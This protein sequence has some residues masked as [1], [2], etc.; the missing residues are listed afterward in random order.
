MLVR[1]E[2]VLWEE[3][4]QLGPLGARTT[5]WGGRV[6]TREAQAPGVLAQ[7]EGGGH[8]VLSAESGHRSGR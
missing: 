5:E 1:S 4:D 6:A 7:L 3:A 8:P 2:G